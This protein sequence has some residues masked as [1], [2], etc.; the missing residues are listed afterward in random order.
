[1]DIPYVSFDAARML[2]NISEA[3]IFDD[4]HDIGYFAYKNRKNHKYHGK[5][6]PD[7]PE[8]FH[9]WQWGGLGI[10]AATIMY[11]IATLNETQKALKEQT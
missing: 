5:K 7:H 6:A 9:H 8:S 11:L 1:M 3:A 4:K 2:Y 10:A